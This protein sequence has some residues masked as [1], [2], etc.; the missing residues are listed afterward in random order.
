MMDLRGSCWGSAEMGMEE[1]YSPKRG[2]KTEMRNILDG[3]A[4][5][6]KVSSAQSPSR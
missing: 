4:M 6:G 3:G 2:M 5:S 1:E